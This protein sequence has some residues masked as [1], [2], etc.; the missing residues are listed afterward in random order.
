LGALAAEQY[1]YL[2]TVGRRS[3][4]PHTIEIWFGAEGA[5]LF[6]IS[7]GADRS[8]WVRN[9]QADRRASVR[10]ADSV[11]AVDARVPLTEP[12]ER[13]RAVR[14]LHDKY[15][16]QVSSTLADWLRDAFIVALDPIVDADRRAS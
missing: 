8:D 14:L 7:G 12:D 11:F 1:C 4:R 6:L 15:G 9:L 16:G 5:G 2:T 13:E 10:L 3:G